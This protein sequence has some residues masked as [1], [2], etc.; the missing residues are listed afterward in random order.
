MDGRGRNYS[1]DRRHQSGR[2]M[3]EAVIRQQVDDGADTE[4]RA[5]RAARRRS[6]ERAQQRAALAEAS[7]A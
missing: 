1:H 3:R 2:A 4:D 7:D 6:L 5:A